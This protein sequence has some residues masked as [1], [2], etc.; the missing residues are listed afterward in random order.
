MYL[1][2]RIKLAADAASRYSSPHY[3]VTTLLLG[4]P[5]EIILC[6]IISQETHNNIYIT[7]KDFSR[8][9][10]ADP[11]VICCL[12]EDDSSMSFPPEF[13]RYKNVLYKYKKECC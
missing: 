13:M 4:E 1:P 11:V 10:K 7:L 3:N 6:A 8:G 2:G 5:Q 12:L 9:T